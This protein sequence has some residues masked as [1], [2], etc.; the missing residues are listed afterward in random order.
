MLIKEFFS[1]ASNSEIDHELFFCL[2]EAL[3][4]HDSEDGIF[5]LN[6]VGVNF[7]CFLFHFTL[8]N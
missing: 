4:L 7:L 6:L 3:Q 5:P 8:I 1:T 2:R